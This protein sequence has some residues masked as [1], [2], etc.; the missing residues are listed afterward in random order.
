MGLSVLKPTTRSRPDFCRILD[1]QLKIRV[2]SVEFSA[3]R[4]FG[5][6]GFFGS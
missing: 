2:Q 6:I 4:V 5:F 1:S 3:Y